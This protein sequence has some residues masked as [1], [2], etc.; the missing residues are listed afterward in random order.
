MHQE[1]VL[2]CGRQKLFTN[3]ECAFYHYVVLVLFA[4]ELKIMCVLSRCKT[5]PLCHLARGSKTLTLTHTHTHTHTGNVGQQQGT[6]ASQHCIS[7]DGIA[8]SHKK[9]AAVGIFL[10]F[11]GKILKITDYFLKEITKLLIA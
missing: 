6:D 4:G 9:Q 7:A 3:A 8:L 2:F 10:S 5:C 11:S 1:V